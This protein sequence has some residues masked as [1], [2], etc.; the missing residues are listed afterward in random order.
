MNTTEDEFTRGYDW[1]AGRMLRGP[2]R[3]KELRE[4]LRQ[5][6][7]TAFNKGALAA[8]DRFEELTA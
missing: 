8:I 1:A 2:V 3:P 4:K 6:A 7:H 5:L